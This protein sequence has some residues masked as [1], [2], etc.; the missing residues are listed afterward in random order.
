MKF[1]SYKDLKLAALCLGCAQFGQKY[2]IANKDGVGDDQ[3]AAIIAKAAD[4][5]VN[6]FD[7][8]ADYGESETILGKSRAA[9][10]DI[11]I[12][13]KIKYFKG[14]ANAAAIAKTVRESVESSL[15]NLR[16]D[17]LDIVYI[18]QQQL[19]F[20]YPEAFLEAL[21]ACKDK[22]WVNHIGISLYEP[23]EVDEALK[24]DEI[25][26]FQIVYNA[27]ARSFETSGKIDLLRQQG[28]LVAPRSA[29]LLGLLLMAPEALPEFFNPVKAELENFYKEIGDHFDSREEFFL[30][31]VSSKGFGPVILG[32]SSLSQLDA[33]LKIF[34]LVSG[35]AAEKFKNI[36]AKIPGLA[37]CYLDPRNWKL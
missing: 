1:Y 3:A 12:A 4:A 26:V 23:R 17:C 10:S 35:Q 32:I 21:A 16:R 15:R 24:Y 33:N 13:T 34:D 36:E 31:Y 18:H 11:V 37:D 8:A 30:G 25:E 28:K 7:T 22:G 5:G 27:L 2:G 9:R 6:F 14:E 19:F 29:F 20:K